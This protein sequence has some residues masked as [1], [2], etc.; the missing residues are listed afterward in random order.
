LLVMDQPKD[1][2][3]DLPIEPLLPALRA[4]LGDGVSAVVQA[5]PGAGKTTRVPLALLGEE[6]LRGGKIVMLEPRRL[7]ARAAAKRMADMLGEK[8]GQT[9]GYRVRLDTVVSRATRI[10]V[11]TAGVFI[12]LIQEDPALESVAAVLFDEFH[13]RS[14]DVDLGLAFCLDA[15]QTLRPDLRLVAMSATL[16]GG[17]IAHLLG[18]APALTSEGRQ[19]PVETR[20][21]ARDPRT[22]LDETVA[23]AIRRAL[24]DSEGDLLAF[25]PGVG[26]IRRVQVRVAEFAGS[27]IDVVPLYSDLPLDQQDAAIRPAPRG[28]R[29]IVLATSIAETSLT[30]EGVRTVI[31]GGYMRLPRF[32]PATGMSRL[33]TVRVSRA[34]ADQRRG[35]AGRLAPGVC[36]RLWTEP[37]D[38][39]LLAQTPPEIR[40]A[41][42]A[43]LALELAAW[44]GDVEDLAWLDP[45]P[46]AGLAAARDLL[47]TAK[48]ASQRKADGWPLS[49]RIRGSH[50]CFC[51]ATR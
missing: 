32:D 38:R 3:T 22:R 44:G 50:T 14:L 31:D 19:Y 15:R 23:A 45:P 6:W 26:D 4:Q 35:R 43:P 29:K 24:P 1:I 40:D 11:V 16:D 25:L 49:A 27:E 13:E 48:D 10:E 34:S 2:S 21:L 17:P 33:E 8:V 51:A 37:T 30:I 5:P 41:D 7:A 36:Y 12:R 47:S 39:A 20:Y 9:V 42:L 28:R 18:G 46:A